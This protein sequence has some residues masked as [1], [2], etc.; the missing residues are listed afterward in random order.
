MRPQKYTFEQRKEWCEAYLKGEH[1][2]TPLGARRA[3]FIRE[4]RGW[5]KKYKRFGPDSIDPFG[6]EKGL[7]DSRH[8][9]RRRPRG[10]RRDVDEGG[11]AHRKS[12]F[13]CSRPDEKWTTDVSQFNFDI[14]QLFVPF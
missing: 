4:L 5:A 3:T 9:G 2:P 12:D 8:F 14:R 11:G 13:S 6:K 1:V 10:V 7:S